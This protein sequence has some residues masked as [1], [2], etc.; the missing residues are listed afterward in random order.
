MRKNEQWHC[1]KKTPKF[2]FYVSDRGLCKRIRLR[3]NDVKVYKG[4][5]NKSIGYFVFTN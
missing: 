3:D 5:L 4:G 2:E 1:V